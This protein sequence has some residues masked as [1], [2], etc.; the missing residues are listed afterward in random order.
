MKNIFLTIIISSFFGTAFTQ[1]FSCLKRVIDFK[2]AVTA[3]EFL[4]EDTLVIGFENEEMK[5]IDLVSEKPVYEFHGHYDP[6][7]CIHKHPTKDEFISTGD[8]ALKV[9][10][11]KGENLA[12]QNAHNTSGWHVEYSNDGNLIISSSYDRSIAYRNA[13]NFEPVYEFREHDKSILATAFSNSGK[14]AASGSLDTKVNVYDLETNTLKH[15]F[16][17]HAHTIYSLDFSDNDRLLASAS[18][19]KNIKIWNI[20]TL[21]FYKTLTGHDN[22]VMKVQFIHNDKYV[23]SSSYDM[24]LRMWDVESG[25]C[26]FIFLG[27]EI[28]INDFTVNDDESILYSVAQDGKLIEWELSNKIFADYYYKS[29]ISAEIADSPLFSPKRKGESRADYKER[30]ERAARYL[31]RLYEK[32]YE[33]YLNEIVN[34]SK[35]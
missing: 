12:V 2:E 29:E 4:K 23:I 16:H 19:D 25:I 18:R 22:S 1:N 11:F 33:K 21:E 3:I 17:G 28:P 5:I 13:D 34:D 6:V 26:M 31:D 24:T 20:E 35:N 15:Q 30:E 8:K 14:L 7:R 27:H 9:W 10:D 32:Y